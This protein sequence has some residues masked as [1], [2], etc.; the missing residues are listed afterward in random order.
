MS[1]CTASSLRSLGPGTGLPRCVS[2]ATPHQSPWAPTQ[3]TRVSVYE[4]WCSVQMFFTPPRISVSSR[5]V[6]PALA[7]PQQ[8]CGLSSPL[9]PAHGPPQLQPLPVG[10]AGVLCCPRSWVCSAA[11]I[12]KSESFDFISLMGCIPGKRNRRKILTS[13]RPSPCGCRCWH[14]PSPRNVS[15]SS[16]T[17][18]SSYEKQ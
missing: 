9:C 8:A 11:R 15:V 1:V 16:I 12:S 13:S 7:R 17:Q 18:R 2:P 3:P 14:P 5:R 4:S 6:F 10:L